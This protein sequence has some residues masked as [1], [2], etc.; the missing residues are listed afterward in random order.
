[1]KIAEIAEY[2]WLNSQPIQFG[3]TDDW[4]NDLFK[5]GWSQG[6]PFRKSWNGAG[7][8]W[9]WFSVGMSYDELHA[10]K[11]PATL[12]EKGCNIGLLTHENREVF[13]SPLLCS[14]V[15]GMTVIYNGHEANVTS[16]IRAHFALKNNGT[17]ALGLNHYPLSKKEWVV[18]FFSTP[19]FT[20]I[21]AD[22][23]AQIELLMR[24]YSGR[25]AVESAW[26]AKYGWPVLCKE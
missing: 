7:S 16:R 17:G 24:S 6:K 15:S 1:M 10:V 13:G 9:Y 20:G 23:R 22:D 18:R 4:D 3:G 21:T 11:K 8:G 19:C 2:V 25:C 12:P 26:R 14:P 5:K